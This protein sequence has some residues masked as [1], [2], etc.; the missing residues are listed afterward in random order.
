MQMMG[1]KIKN[2]D[3]LKEQEKDMG[4]ELIGERFGRLLVIQKTQ[5]NVNRPGEKRIAEKW[6]CRCD[7]GTEREVFTVALL[8]KKEPTLSCGC[9]TRDRITK[10]NITH[11]ETY[12]RLFRTWSGMKTRCYNPMSDHWSDYGA[13]GIKICDEWLNNFIVFRDWAM[14]NGYNDNL[15]IDRKDVDG[16]YTPENCRF[17][18]A[19]SQAN[20][21]R[22]NQ[23]LDIDGVKLTYTEWAQRLGAKDRDIINRR[24]KKGWTEKEAV[25]IP[26]GGKRE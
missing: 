20:N 9:Y 26:L 4:R 5:D 14:K 24:L 25:T 6:L 11:G 15:T 16:D 19:K 18:N 7:C 22:S 17:A 13:R 3:I 23:F 10:Q 12:T 2:Y 21:R 1:E 8:R